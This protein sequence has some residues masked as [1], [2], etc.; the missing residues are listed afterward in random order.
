MLK[1]PPAIVANSSVRVTTGAASARATIPTKADGS[2]P[3]Y[4]MVM[5]RG[6]SYIDF[7]GSGV[8]ATDTDS[9]FLVPYQPLFFNV[10]GKTHFAYLEETAGTLIGVSPLENQ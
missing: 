7:G 5:A 6:D 10:A 2:T 8:V 1:S 3:K 4:V 9:I